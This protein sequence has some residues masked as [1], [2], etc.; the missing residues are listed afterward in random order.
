M[1]TK[2]KIYNEALGFLL[3]Q[4]Q[5]ENTDTDKSNEAK[6]LNTHFDAAFRS[7]LEDMDLTS[8]SSQVTLELLQPNPNALWSYAYKYPVDCALFRRI[9]SC[10]RMDDRSS[11]IPREVRML[12][13]TKAIFTD[14]V[15][16]IGEYIS[17]NVPISSLSAS[18]GLAVAAMLAILSAPLVTG[19]G[20]RGLKQ[21]LLEKY[22]LFKA[23]AQ[24]QDQME[25][26]SYT[27][28]WKESEFVAARF[29]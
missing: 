25:S 6:V 19:K 16:A 4:R 15:D 8:T 17:A 9:Q 14:Q 24:E 5:I 27:P 20:A 3:L 12:G 28:P 29:E 10:D 18:A 13:T 11:H 1:W 21:E 23:N 22:A 7:A 2:A 26:F